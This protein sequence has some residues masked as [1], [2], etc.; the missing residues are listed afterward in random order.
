MFQ[1]DQHYQH[2]QACQQQL[3]VALVGKQ[4]LALVAKQGF[5]VQQQLLLAAKQVY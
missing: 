1:V 3:K 4:Q 5:Q 2:N